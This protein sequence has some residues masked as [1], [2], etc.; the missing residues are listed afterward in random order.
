M[1]KHNVWFYLNLIIIYEISFSARNKNGC[2][3]YILDWSVISFNMIITTSALF[4]W[5]QKS[6]SSFVFPPKTRHR[7][8]TNNQT[9]FSSI[10]ECRD[11]INFVRSKL[12]MHITCRQKTLNLSGIFLRCSLVSKN[13]R[14]FSQC[15]P[16]SR[17]HCLGRAKRLKDS[18]KK[19]RIFH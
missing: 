1:P 19:R 14:F 2:E 5:S 15:I 3:R 7:R 17:S 13:K 16:C 8:N 4:F 6:S 10:I 11:F 9:F 12:S 18:E